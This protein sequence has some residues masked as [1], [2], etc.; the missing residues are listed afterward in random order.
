MGFCPSRRELIG[1]VQIIVAILSLWNY[2]EIDLFD[3]PM[4]DI[5]LFEH[6]CVSVTL[7]FVSLYYALGTWFWASKLPLTRM[8]ARIHCILVY[9]ILVMLLFF[10]RSRYIA[11]YGPLIRGVFSHEIFDDEDDRMARSLFII[12]GIM[13]LSAI[14][15]VVQFNYVVKRLANLW[16]KRNHSV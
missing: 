4:Y 9:I 15:V 16:R 10:T 6:Q 3:T 1:F 13:L 12:Q 8:M 2:F 14:I 5:K 11:T 7:C